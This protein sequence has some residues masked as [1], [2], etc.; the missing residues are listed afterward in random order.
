MNHITQIATEASLVGLDAEKAADSVSWPF[1][2]KVLETFGFLK[3]I[4]ET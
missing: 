2:Y 4:T 1:L 3:S